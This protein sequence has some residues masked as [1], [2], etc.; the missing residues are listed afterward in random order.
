MT[1]I[2][3]EFTQI[4]LK[5]F[6]NFSLMFHLILVT[7]HL[8]YLFYRRFIITT[9]LKVARSKYD[10]TNKSV[11]NYFNCFVFSNDSINY[12]L[13]KLYWLPLWYFLSGSSPV[14]LILSM[15]FKGKVTKSAKVWPFGTYFRL[16]LVQERLE[17]TL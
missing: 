7:R 16:Y 2:F 6:I 3:R 4:C 1:L 10:A 13:W 12:I 14:F 15:V 11:R 9:F 5:T 17:F 8:E